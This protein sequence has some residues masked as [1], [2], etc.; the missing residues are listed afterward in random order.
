VPAL[1]PLLKASPA[2]IQDSAAE[3]LGLLGDPQAIPPLRRVLVEMTTHDY[4]ARQ[5]AIEALRRLGDRESVKRVMQIVTE[6][7][8]PPPPGANEPSYDADDTRAEGVRYLEF[9]GEPKLADQMLAKLTEMPSYPLRKVMA[10]MLTK[11]KGVPHLAEFTTDARRYFLDTL[12]GAAYPQSP[13][14]PGIIPRENFRPPET[15]ANPA[16]AR[17]ESPP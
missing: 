2:E 1:I 10:A 5:R 13:A 14:N 8:V 11:L 3:A 17:G 7:V 9:I 15:G 16:A 12:D 4:V 6:K